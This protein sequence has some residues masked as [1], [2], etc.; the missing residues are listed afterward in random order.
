[1]DD[2]RKDAEDG[3]LAPKPSPPDGYPFW[4]W[5]LALLICV[6]WLAWPGRIP[7]IND[8]ALLFINALDANAAGKLCPLGISG[9]VGIRY[10]PVPTWFY[11]FC[12]LF[13]KNPAL[14]AFIKNFCCLTVLLISVHFIIAALELPKKCLLPILLA[15]GFMLFSRSLWD[16]V[17][18]IPITAALIAVYA[19]FSRKPRLVHLL[20]LGSLALLAIHVHLMVIPF[21]IPLALCLAL[22]WRWFRKKIAASGLVLAAF[23]CA[24]APYAVYV[25]KNI[26]FGQRG[27]SF[28]PGNL[29]NP[30]LGARIFSYYDFFQ[31]HLTGLGI[32]NSSVIKILTAVS[33]LALI[34]SV[35]G[36]VLVCR[37]VFN[38]SKAKTAWSVKMKIELLAVLI[39]IFSL[40]FYVFTSHPG[41]AHYLNSV[42]IAY[43]IFLWRGMECLQSRIGG[44][45]IVN[46]YI[47]VMALM[48]FIVNFRVH[49]NG[50]NRDYR[51]GAMLDN[52]MEAARTVVRH[53]EPGRTRIICRVGNYKAFPHSL[54]CLLRL[55]EESGVERGAAAESII[56]DYSSAP[57]SGFIEA[58]PVFKRTVP[59]N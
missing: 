20:G 46:S 39:V 13:T 52:Q 29:I 1:M 2:A 11:Q 56:I 15:P 57:P 50:G 4:V 34:F 43:A 10:G 31:V 7:W 24:C 14:I 55:A 49:A 58:V 17:F 37:D 33:C 12:L 59:L 22:D 28:F 47:I 6:V 16:N 27:E 19:A 51:H 44:V 32:D 30:L 40:L 18:L 3:A 8:D 35:M 21:L 48:M 38:A 36:F 26:K 42:W 9:T 23:L 41:H 25:F 54:L 5:S 53:F 45:M